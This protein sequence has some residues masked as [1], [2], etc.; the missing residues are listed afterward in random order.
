MTRHAIKNRS[1]PIISSQ[2][3]IHQ[4][5]EHDRPYNDDNF[6]DKTVA[7]NAAQD[8]LA[9]WGRDFI[10]Y[11]LPPP[12]AQPPHDGWPDDQFPD[13]GAHADRRGEPLQSGEGP[14]ASFTHQGI[15]I[16][17]DAKALAREINSSHARAYLLARPEVKQS[18]IPRLLANGILSSRASASI[19][20]ALTPTQQSTAMRMA[21]YRWHGDINTIARALED[22]LG[23]ISVSATKALRDLRE[24]AKHNIP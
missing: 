11:S 6:L 10:K 23:L 7:L 13:Y 14:R 18:T 15:R 9:G 21:L 2:T 12:T 24:T 22:N 8:R 19:A 16:T 17:G 20:A 4:K 5:N 1:A 3:T